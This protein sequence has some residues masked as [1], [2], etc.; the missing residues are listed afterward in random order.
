M[1][2]R[3]IIENLLTDLGLAL[4]DPS[5]LLERYRVQPIELEPRNDIKRA[6]IALYEISESVTVKTD[7]GYSN[8]S[9]QRYGLDISVIRAYTRD[10]ASRGELPL[11]DLRDQVID[12]ANTVDAG[13]LTG[14]A[15]YT[16]S[17]DG[18]TGITRNDRYVT[19]TLQFSALRNLYDSQTYG[20]DLTT[21]LT[22][23]NDNILLDY[24]GNQLT[25]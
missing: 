20:P 10:D 22:D 19:M 18:S 4:S 3:R 2:S 24:N 9:T 21:Y 13:L 7:P 15:I 6:R 23:S 17:Y 16:F 11:L 25:P 12:W 5:V 14:T 8:L 1:V